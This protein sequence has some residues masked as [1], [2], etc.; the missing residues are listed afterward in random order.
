MRA[1]V[2]YCH[3]VETSFCS[4]VH[5][6]AVASLA[7]AG[8][9][10]RDLDLY[11]RNF[12]PVLS[13]QERIDYHTETVN[14]RHVE[15][16]VEDILWAEALVFVYP[17]WWYSLP[18]M[19]KGWLDRVWLPHVTFGL[20]QGPNPIVPKM[21]HIRAIIGVTT[22]GAPWWLVRA[23][24]DPGRKTLLRG[25]RP[26]CGLRCR[27]GWLAHYKMDASTA[28]TRARFLRRVEHKLPR[29]LG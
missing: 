5:R 3:P 18:A 13:R 10:L 23:S 12:Q 27:T 14:R 29:L 26:L 24:G 20:Q 2:V 11:R 7:D 6:A 15:D 19:L 17:T 28:Q 21:R 1:L 8:H 22:Y 4:A 25:I 9:E 16:Y